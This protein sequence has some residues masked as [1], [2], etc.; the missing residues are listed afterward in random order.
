MSDWEPIRPDEPGS[1]SGTRPPLPGTPA[2]AETPPSM[3]APQARPRV[4]P[5]RVA[6]PPKLIPIPV[7]IGLAAI[8]VLALTAAW[9]ATSVSSLHSDVRELRAEVGDIADELDAT[10]G[11]EAGRDQAIADLSNRLTA[12]ETQTDPAAVAAAVQPSVFTV[13]AGEFLGS[14]F[15]VTSDGVTSSLATNYHVVA[16]VYESGGRDVVVYQ[17][18]NDRLDAVID[19]VSPGDDLALLVVQKA[20]A[21]LPRSTAP[22]QPGAPVLAIGSPLGLGG[23]VSSGSVS[24]L[25]SFE[26]DQ[27]IQFSAPISPGNSGGP[28]VDAQGQVIGITVAKLVG[29]GAEGLAFALPVSLLCV[30]LQVC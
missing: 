7:V 21:P 6:P 14:G 23:S 29:G 26:G 11:E 17:D 10:E 28:L 3:G 25:R 5:S 27:Y 16:D 2:S 9:L 8:V 4:D 24:A 13:E 12:I 22:I 1:L 19:R 30:R 15:V 20:L 18:E